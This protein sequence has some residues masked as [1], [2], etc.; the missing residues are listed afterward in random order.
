MDAFVIRSRSKPE[1]SASSSRTASILAFNDP[2]KYVVK[3]ASSAPRG[4]LN[5][6]PKVRGQQKISDLKGVVSI[7]KF[8]DVVRQLKDQSVSG[9]TKIT[10]LRSLRDK[11]PSTQVIQ[12][13][14][15]GKVVRQLS[16]GAGDEVQ[17]EA[18]KVYKDWKR[19]VE[20]RVQKKIA[21]K[22]IEVACDEDTTKARQTTVS[23]L[24]QALAKAN[25]NRGG[26]SS[27]LSDKD[28]VATTQ[29]EKCLFRLCGN[30]L[31][32]RYRRAG[33]KIVFDLTYQKEQLD[34]CDIDKLVAKHL[35]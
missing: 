29:I 22:H 19:L 32:K 30:L 12:S 25:Q 2:K 23:L 9:K 6:I 14:G 27:S 15:I 33:R 16:Q 8:E 5:S 3:A 10:L 18:Q 1:D 35:D 31:N 28:K 4:S 21:A 17:R 34:L 26:S 13:T 24:R 7:D 11:K 20:S